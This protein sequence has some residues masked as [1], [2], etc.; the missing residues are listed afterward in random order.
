MAAG[1]SLT[2][3]EGTVDPL[4][5]DHGMVDAGWWRNR[6]WGE[7]VL[8]SSL[9]F[10]DISVSRNLAYLQ[11]TLSHDPHLITVPRIT[12][13]LTTSELREVTQTIARHIY[14]LTDS[15]GEPLF[16]G[17]YYGSQWGFDLECW[18]LFD[19]RNAHGGVT[20]YDVLPSTPG[21]IQAASVLQLSIQIAD[22]RY[23]RPWLPVGF[24]ANATP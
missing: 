4:Y 22:D 16:S 15:L 12:V 17:I 21:L 14:E 10:F 1:L 18:A 7:T 20:S 8:D 9:R 11:R 24:D 19:R 3:L 13:A 6:R 5:P 23:L 2:D